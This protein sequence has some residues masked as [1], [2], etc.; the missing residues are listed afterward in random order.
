MK[1]KQ[2]KVDN[3]LE[4]TKYWGPSSNTFL[5]V[6][7]I[8]NF[9]RRALD[10]GCGSFRNSKYLFNCGFIIDAI[11]KDPRVKNY[12]GFFTNYIK[13]LSKKY[14][15]IF[16]LRIADYL[17]CN[18]GKN[19]YDIVVSENSLSLNKKS[20]VKNMIRKIY[21]ALKDGGY[22]AGNL[23]GLRDFRVGK[24]SMSFYTKKEAKLLLSEFKI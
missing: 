2:E 12:T 15:K 9:K 16:N 14:K 17:K 20:D 23:Y 4:D 5:S 18:L 1:K 11:D 6:Q 7:L 13:L 10:L 3:Y 22:F 8:N 19:K 21:I 24:K